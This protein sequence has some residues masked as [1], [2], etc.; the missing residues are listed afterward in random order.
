[1]EKINNYTLHEFLT[2]ESIDTINE[3]MTVLEFLQPVKEVDDPIYNDYPKIKIKPVS[4]L[5]FGEVT[6]LRMYFND[7]IIDSICEAVRLVTGLRIHE[8]YQMPIV[9]F[10]SI[11]ATI[12]R[13]LELLSNMEINALT[14][15]EHDPI[16]MQVQASERMSRFGILNL[17]NSLAGDDITKWEQIEK[18]P[19]MVV[20]TKLQMDK[21][22]GDINRDVKAIQE[23]KNKNR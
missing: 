23:L 4:S 2:L 22:R 16:M 12:K 9:D 17:I 14:D 3:Y 6:N 8:I 19:Y 21:T 13:D 11:L 20:F 7:G 5:L 15:E 10:Y 18:M 1:M